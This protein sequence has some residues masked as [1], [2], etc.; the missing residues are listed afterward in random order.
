MPRKNNPKRTVENILS[1]SEKLF[2]EKGYDQTSMQNIVDALG[3]SK[4]AIFHHFGSKEEIFTAVIDRQSKDAE[5]QM[6][7]WIEGM[8]EIPA[9]EKITRLLEMILDDARMHDLSALV[10]Q[11]QSPRMIVAT[12]RDNVDNVA[13]MI[14]KIIKEGAA[15]GSIKTDF[16][17]ECAQVLFLLLNIWCVP[18]VFDFDS[19]DSHR[20]LLFIQRMMRQFGLD[21]L[22]DDVITK[23]MGFTKN[24]FTEARNDG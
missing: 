24:L 17:D 9:R 19:R 8:G 13:P 3:M 15:D 22:S 11:N 16:P 12:M 21:V 14:A 23:Y 5:R 1:V 20:R 7:E 18:T 4:G 2:L 6:S 10:N